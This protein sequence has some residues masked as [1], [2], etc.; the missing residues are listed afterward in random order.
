MRHRALLVPFLSAVCVL[1]GWN[2]LGKA[3]EP[4]DLSGKWHG[5][6]VSCKT[7]HHGKLNGRFCKINDTCYQVRFSGTFFG[8]VPFAF[9]VKLAANAQEDGSVALSGDP[10]LPLFG[11]FHFSAMAT[12]HDFSATYSA[13]NDEGRFT[14]S[15]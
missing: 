14:L 2:S 9:T 10:R 4:V 15:R 8:A 6:W 7:G 13:R 11:T 3:A 12:E 5:T 1:A